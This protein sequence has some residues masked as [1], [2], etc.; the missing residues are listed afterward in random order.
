M[1]LPQPTLRAAPAWSMARAQC[2]K[3]L[4]ARQTQATT[5]QGVA[6]GRCRQAASPSPRPRFWMRPTTESLL[7][8]RTRLM[9]PP[10]SQST[11]PKVWTWSSSPLL[12]AHSRITRRGRVAHGV[13]NPVQPGVNDPKTCDCVTTVAA[14]LSQR[15]DTGLVKLN[16]ETVVF[17]ASGGS[18]MAV[19][20]WTGAK[21][22]EFSTSESACRCLSRSA[23][24]TTTTIP[25]LTTLSF[26]IASSTLQACRLPP[27]LSYL[28]LAT[29]SLAPY[30]ACCC[31]QMRLLACWPHALTMKRL[32]FLTVPYTDHCK[33]ETTERQECVLPKRTGGRA[34]AHIHR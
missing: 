23:A 30:E 9:R 1:A 14:G 8:P 17:G 26:R 16:N 25:A 29:L 13:W 7:S 10:F 28:Q 15:A 5:K 34:V 19:N 2:A 6:L 21:V 12:I 32:C 22:W 31:G 3:P 11:L 33:H 20:S 24:A 18:L 27:H 4:L